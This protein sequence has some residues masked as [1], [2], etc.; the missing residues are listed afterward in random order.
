MSTLMYVDLPNF[1]QFLIYILAFCTKFIFC[2][3]FILLNVLK[4]VYGIPYRLSWKMFHEH[5]K[6]KYTLLFWLLVFRRCLLDRSQKIPKYSYYYWWTG[7][8]NWLYKVCYNHIQFGSLSFSFLQI[9][10]YALFS[11]YLKFPHLRSTF[12]TYFTCA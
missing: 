3:T 8:F 5:V 6:R 12:F 4:L 2:M 7:Y 10:F 1:F 11:S 9:S